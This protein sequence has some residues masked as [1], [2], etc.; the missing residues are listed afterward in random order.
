M[1]PFT[2]DSAKSKIDK[3]PKITNWVKLKTNSSTAEQLSNEWS[4]FGVLSIE[5]KV[6]KLC[7][8][9]GFT[10]PGVKGLRYHGNDWLH[11]SYRSTV[12]VARNRVHQ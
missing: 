12:G 4:H 6:R 9:Q 1:N 10:L 2:L 5:S 11:A 8:T 7:I 3:F